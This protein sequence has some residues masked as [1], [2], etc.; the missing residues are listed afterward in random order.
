LPREA[1][2]TIVR[3]RKQLL[4]RYP[5]AHAYLFGS[6]ANGTWVEDSDF[7]VIVVSES[8]RGQAFAERVKA[9]RELA[10]REKPFEILAYTPSE[11]REAQRR[12]V[13]IQDAR[14]YWRRIA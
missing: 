9:V 14:K 3:F 13:V 6:Y 7:D 4:A 5:D 11:F 8:F 2:R 10:A 12:S 1:E